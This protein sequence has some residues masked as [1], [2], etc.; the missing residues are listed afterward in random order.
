[1]REITRE[2][3]FHWDYR[4]IARQ[5]DGIIKYSVE[6]VYY[7]GDGTPI[8]RDHEPELLSAETMEELIEDLGTVTDAFNKP[9]LWGGDDENF[10]KEY[11]P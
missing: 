4:I 11:K 6:A 3:T 5:L 8:F 9:V 10:L 7:G 2:I 1:M